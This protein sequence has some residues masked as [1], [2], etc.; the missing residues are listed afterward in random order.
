ME[1]SETSSGKDKTLKKYQKTKMN[2]STGIG[3]L[4][5]SLIASA[6]EMCAQRLQLSSKKEREKHLPGLTDL[7]DPQ[8]L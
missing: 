2:Y 3:V 4:V 7:I 1:F 8:G 5:A 6:I